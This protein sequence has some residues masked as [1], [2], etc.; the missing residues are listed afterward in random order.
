MSQTVEGNCMKAC[1]TE[2]GEEGSWL[3][4]LPG[5]RCPRCSFLV[6]SLTRV[7]S[8]Y[9]TESEGSESSYVRYNTTFTHGQAVASRATRPLGCIESNVWLFRRPTF[10]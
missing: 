8:G 2:I 3:M 5:T 7:P 9:K 1:L 6:H 10:G 4:V